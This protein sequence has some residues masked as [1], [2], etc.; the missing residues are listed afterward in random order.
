MASVRLI[1]D[2]IGVGFGTAGLGGEC[3]NA[4]LTALD[5]GFRKFDTAE[6]DWW[7]DQKAVGKAL[8]SFFDP[9]DQDDECLAEECTRTCFSEGL[10]ISTKI[11]PWS[12]TSEADIRM[13]AR[14]SRQE[15]VGF[16]EDV[17]L[18]DKDGNIVSARPYPLDVYFIHAPKCWANWHPRCKA[19]PEVLSLRDAWVAMEAVVGLDY[20][21]RRIGLSNVKPHELLDIISFV[22]ERKEAGED[23]V[24]PP[25]RMPDAVQILADPLMPAKE[26]RRICKEYGIEFVAFS[27]LG[28]QHKSQTNP[29]LG[30]EVVKTLAQT[31]GRSVAEVVLSWA[32]QNDMSVIPRSNKKDHIAELANLLTQPPFLSAADLSLVDSLSLN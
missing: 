21:S 25:P 23:N 12:L 17:V 4:V 10:Q 29:V 8:E 22:K 24:Q 19:P 32:L 27:T 31:H 13:H 18:A 14:E 16:C 20:S 3:Y 11:P 5:A 9:G 15:L 7:Y 2:A 28:L 26:I 6:A 30:S 1:P